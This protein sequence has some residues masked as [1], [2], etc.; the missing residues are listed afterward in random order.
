MIWLILY[1]L[2][3]FGEL[4]N[5]KKA[6]NYLPSDFPNHTEDEVQSKIY[7]TKQ[8]A[9]FVMGAATAWIV[10]GFIAVLADTPLALNALVGIG[11]FAL[12]VVSA[13]H[14]SAA[15]KINNK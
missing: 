1:G 14:G 11:I 6:D 3:I 10:W 5:I 2:L 7:N 4:R 12:F 13:T 15:A 8:S 9:Y